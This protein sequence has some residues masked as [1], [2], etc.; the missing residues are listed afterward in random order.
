MGLGSGN[1]G[2]KKKLE[3][4]YYED[5]TSRCSWKA[6]QIIEWLEIVDEG[7]KGT[8]MKSRNEWNEESIPRIVVMGK[9]DI[10]NVEAIER[11]R[12]QK[13]IKHLTTKTERARTSGP[14]TDPVPN[15]LKTRS[16]KNMLLSKHLTSHQDRS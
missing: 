12:K 13:I 14:Y 11:K 5:K 6:G 1:G 15:A 8:V 3:N 16:K 9:Y 7:K 2:Q 10:E 4:T